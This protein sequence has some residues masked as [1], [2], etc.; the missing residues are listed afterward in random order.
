MHSYIPEVTF[1]FPSIPHRIL[2]DHVLSQKWNKSLVLLPSL[3]TVTPILVPGN[4]LNPTRSLALSPHSLWEVQL[5]TVA[6]SAS[7]TLPWTCLMSLSPS[8]EASVRMERF[9]KVCRTAFPVFTSEGQAW[10]SLDLTSAFVPR[11]LFNKLL[12]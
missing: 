10:P 12:A 7:Q 11:P 3:C 9:L 2:E 6:P 8:V 4:G 5:Q 1:D